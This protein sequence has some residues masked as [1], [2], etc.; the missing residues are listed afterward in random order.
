MGEMGDLIGAQGA[1]AAGMLGP[2]E[3]TGLEEGAVEDQL[4]PALE[5]V[6]EA[7]LAVGPVEHVLLLHGHP[8]HPP[9]LGGHLIAGA[10]QRLL[11][12]EKLLASLLPLLRRH[13][14]GC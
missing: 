2:A 5:K 8:R 3:D 13:D 10:G 14:G 11:L 12:H 7:D 4:S 6:E 1:A 9:A